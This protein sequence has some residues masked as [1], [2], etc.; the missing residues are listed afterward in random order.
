MPTV[1]IVIPFYNTPL[2]YTRQ[3]LR[4]VVRQTLRDW[5]AFVVNDGS[6]AANSAA[7]Q[8]LIA[9]IDDPRII[10]VSTPNGGV[11]AARNIGVRSGTSPFVAFLDSDDYWY[12]GKLERQVAAFAEQ[13]Q[14]A[15]VH[16]AVD[17]LSG[18][19][20][21]TSPPA[22]A[23][24]ISQLSPAEQLQLLLRK[25]FI[26]VV[27]VMMRREAFEAVGGFDESLRVVEDKELWIRTMI[28][29]HLTAFVDRHLAVYRHHGASISRNTGK[30][31]AG[32]LHLIEQVGRQLALKGSHWP[33]LDWDRERRYMV[34]HAYHEAAEGCLESGSF[35]SALRY[36]VTPASGW[37]TRTAHLALRSVVGAVRHLRPASAGA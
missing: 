10:Y 23:R 35:L 18:D 21:V 11:S 16:T 32:R 19:G 14:V 5:Q 7:L 15:L 37:S 3:T 26:G 27:T 34:A 2:D 12:P 9:E 8:G 13:P 25:N 36:A 20:Q 4:S 28:H 30:M 17:I 31:L 29:G 33:T 6:T 22:L 1:D 24:T